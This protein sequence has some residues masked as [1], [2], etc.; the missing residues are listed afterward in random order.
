MSRATAPLPNIYNNSKTVWINNSCIDHSPVIA[1]GS[2]DR[3]QQS[4]NPSNKSISKRSGRDVSNRSL[5][6]ASRLSSI[7]STEISTK[8]SE[9]KNIRSKSQRVGM[10]A[11]W[12]HSETPVPILQPTTEISS[13]NKIGLLASRLLQASTSTLSTSILHFISYRILISSETNR[14]MISTRKQGP[15]GMWSMRK[16]FYPK[17]WC[18][19]V[20]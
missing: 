10:K 17:G 11:N 19:S 15:T 4:L 1:P 6:P 12:G 9:R 16:E 3:N 14:N 2:R 13:L 7:P 18:C 20:C 5:T 8:G